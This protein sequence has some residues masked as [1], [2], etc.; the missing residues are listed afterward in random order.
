MERKDLT[1]AKTRGRN[2]LTKEDKE[3]IKR[4][5]SK[6]ESSET[7]AKWYDISAFAVEKIAGVLR[8]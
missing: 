6:G 4:R 3:E 8:E 2:Y 1:M 7:V 5:I